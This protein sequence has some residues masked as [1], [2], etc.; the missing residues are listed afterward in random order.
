L[1]VINNE[2]VAEVLTM[3]DC[4]SAQEEA[5]KQLPSGGAIHRPRI[6]MYMPCDREDG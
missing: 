3:Q 2:I 1:L 5:F 4:I 6:D